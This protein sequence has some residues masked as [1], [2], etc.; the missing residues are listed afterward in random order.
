MSAVIIPFPSRQS[1][2]P[3]GVVGVELDKLAE[4]IHH[5]ANRQPGEPVTLDAARAATLHAFESMRGV[6]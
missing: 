4:L 3:D 6:R 2:W 5:R 1:R